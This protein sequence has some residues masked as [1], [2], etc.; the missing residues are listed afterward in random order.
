MRG[1]S[2]GVPRRRFFLPRSA[3]FFFRLT[4]ACARS[5]AFDIYR[6]HSHSDA[7]SIAIASNGV[8]EPSLV[9]ALEPLAPVLA[10]PQFGG[11]CS[12]FA[13]VT[14]GTACTGTTSLMIAAIDADCD[15]DARFG[16][17]CSAEQ[18]ARAKDHPK[19]SKTRIY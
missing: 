8:I 18:Q 17:P 3:V 14:G 7:S 6:A 9:A 1:L 19:G 5:H 16:L 12:S 10:F 2:T 11:A 4:R 15:F 13:F